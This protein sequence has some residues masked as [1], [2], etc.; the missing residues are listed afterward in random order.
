MLIALSVCIIAGCKKSS[1]GTRAPEAKN[2]KISMATHRSGSLFSTYTLTYDD[3]DRV[4]TMTYNGSDTYTRHFSYMNNIIFIFTDVGASSYTDTV[5]LNSNGFIDN[6]IEKIQNDVYQYVYSYGSS[7]I[8]ETS[9]LNNSLAIIYG[10]SFYNGDLIR[11]AS[12]AM[13]PGT[14]DTSTYYTDKPLVTGDPAQ[15]EQYTSFGS[16]FYKDKHLLKSRDS[17]SSHINYTYQFDS[18]GK[19]TSY[20]SRTTSNADTVSYT[21]SC[22]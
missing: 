16:Y 3:S 9:L 13:A 2:C 10:Y 1:S 21:Y 11:N 17:S 22:R 15:F 18:D 8:E 14:A 5:T 19:I 4:L 7:K 12:S 6:R 20:I